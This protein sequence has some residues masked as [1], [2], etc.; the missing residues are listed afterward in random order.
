MENSLWTWKIREF[1]ETGKRSQLGSEYAM[2]FLH[3][4][5]SVFERPASFIREQAEKFR[6][7]KLKLENDRSSGAKR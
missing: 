7:S 5:Q 2:Q 1:M 4:E 6:Q 3:Q